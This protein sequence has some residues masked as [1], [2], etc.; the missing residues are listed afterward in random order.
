MP[1][2]R[3]EACV[4]AC[5]EAFRGDGEILASPIGLIPM[6]AVRLARHTFEPLLLFTDGEACVVEGTWP[7][8]PTATSLRAV[9]TPVPAPWR[10]GCPTGPSSTSSGG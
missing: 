2:C 5:A 10:A 8:A 3:A 7:V 1:L 4:I 6:I 9:G